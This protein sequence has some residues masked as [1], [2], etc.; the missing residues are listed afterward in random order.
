MKT[1]KVSWL[2]LL[3]GFAVGLA[4]LLLTQ[5]YFADYTGAL[6]STGVFAFSST[7]ASLISLRFSEVYY[8]FGFLIGSAL[9]MAASLADLFLF[10]RKLNYHVLCT[11]PLVSKDRSGLFSDAQK[12]LE[13]LVH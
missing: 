6:I 11:Q 2:V 1:K 9:F 13:R 8:G 3:A 7:I 5:L 4:A 10:T 12:V